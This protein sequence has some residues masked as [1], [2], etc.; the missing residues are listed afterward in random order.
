M[1]RL[2][3]VQPERS[4]A[5]VRLRSFCVGRHRSALR[6]ACRDCVRFSAGPGSTSSTHADV[7][8]IRSVSYERC[9]DIRSHGDG[10]FDP[11]GTR[12]VRGL[13]CPDSNG[14]EFQSDSTDVDG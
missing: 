4:E 2:V 3:L 5:M 13:R 14:V 1:K 7:R 10:S 8:G 6:S 9:L 12:G 11:P